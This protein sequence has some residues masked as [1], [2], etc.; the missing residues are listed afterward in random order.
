MSALLL[1]SKP[2]HFTDFYY[3]VLYVFVGT[4]RLKQ[5][6]NLENNWTLILSAQKFIT[7]LAN[8][9]TLS[10]DVPQILMFRLQT[11]FC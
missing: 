9:V 2:Q 6:Q 10:K 5:R 3:F 7:N 8:C 4:C 11:L 1:M